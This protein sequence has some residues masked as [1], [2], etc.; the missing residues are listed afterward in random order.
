MRR[1]QVAVVTHPAVQEILEAVPWGEI[2]AIR[3]L[4]RQ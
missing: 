1:P 2:V 4:E 3:E